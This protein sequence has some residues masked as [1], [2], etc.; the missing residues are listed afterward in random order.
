MQNLSTDLDRLIAYSRVLGTKPQMIQAAGGNTSVKSDGVMWIKASGRWLSDVDDKSS[1]LSMD[2]SRILVALENP[3]ATDAD[4]RACV[5]NESVAVRPSVEVPMHAAIPYRF[6]VHSH[7]VDVI[8][9]LIQQDAEQRLKKCLEGL[10]W[11]FVPY[12]KPGVPLSR[13]V[14]KAA[15]T[16]TQIFFLANHGLIVAGNTL[17]EIDSVTQRVLRRL[18]KNTVA[19]MP[20]PKAPQLALKGSG[21][22]WA[23]DPIS[24]QIAH[25]ETW[26]NILSKGSFTPD[27]LVF[28][29]PA[30]PVLELQ[31]TV[32][33]D[34]AQLAKSPLPFNCAVIVRG[35]GVALRDDAYVGSEA[36]LRCA[37]DVLSVL[38]EDSDIAYFSE[39]E[40][41]ELLNWDS[42]KYRQALNEQSA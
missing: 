40:Q 12:V 1:F 2:L 4:M 6:V 11:A 31:D 35:V 24:H 37:R 29:G 14:S 23:K 26:I 42:E 30:L 28:L 27:I 10:D 3:E 21:F 8:A 16:G 7:C 32:L 5:C 17:E 25:D 22:S 20:V 9:I 39:K 36:L 38:P 15:Q 18:A 34:L 41:F 19:T 33:E 13:V